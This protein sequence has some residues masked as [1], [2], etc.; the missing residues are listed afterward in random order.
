MHKYVIEDQKIKEKSKDT[1]SHSTEQWSKSIIAPAS[2]ENEL[3]AL[4]CL[5]RRR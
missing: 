5:K 4:R 1:R 3:R 2:V